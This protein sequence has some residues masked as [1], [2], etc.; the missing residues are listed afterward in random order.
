L[1]WLASSRFSI[2]RHVAV[3]TL[4]TAI[5]G[6]ALAS[7]IG[8]S[9]MQLE[10]RQQVLGSQAT[11]LRDLLR[12]QDSV[13]QWMLLSDLVLASNET[14]LI[15]GA[16]GQAGIATEIVAQIGASPLAAAERASLA[17]LTWLISDNSQ[18]LDKAGAL[19]PEDSS[20]LNALMRQWDDVATSTHMRA[21]A[22]LVSRRYQAERRRLV[23]ESLAALLLYGGFVAWLWRRVRRA[24]VEPLGRIT[25]A[26]DE[27]MRTGEPIDVHEEGPAEVRRL[28][29]SARS[30]ARVLE[31]RVQDR[32]AA[33][34][35][36][37]ETRRHAE[38]AADEARRTA[39]QA[40]AAKSQFIANMSHEIRTPLNGILGTAE[41]LLMSPLPEP[42]RER[43]ATVGS[44]G[45]LLLGIVNDI[46]DFSKIDAGRLTVQSAPLAMWQLVS[47]LQQ[48][49]SP[50]ALAAQLELRFVI[51]PETPAWLRA[52]ELRLKQILTNLLGNA[53]KFTPRGSVTLTIGCQGI[54]Q[55]RATLR[56]SVADT[57][58][59]ISTAQQAM[60]FE[61]FAQAD[62]S[63]T[64]R[65]GGTG[66][67]LS[68][69]DRLVQL[70]GGQLTCH[71]V[72]DRGSTFSFQLTLETVDAA[73]IA[74][75]APA[76]AAMPVDSRDCV[77]RVLL[78]EDNEVN[79]LVASE[80]LALLGCTV[81][82]VGDGRVATERAADN[83]YDLILMDWHMPNLDGL[84]ATRLIRARESG[85]G[86][87]RTP[88]IALTASA[89]PE[90][91]ARC[92][93]AGMDDFLP[94]PINLDGLRRVL[95]RWLPG[96]GTRLIV[97]AA[98]DVAN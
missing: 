20:A 82:V 55:R 26:A 22:G 43:L 54:D 12:L 75:R 29:R 40:N 66:L 19:T 81:E 78:A 56:F 13:R 7:T 45:R 2:G 65:Y 4:A 16:T 94:K 10:S 36:E 80:M 70:M 23:V 72:L 95:A 46:L 1:A 71:S 85:H 11:V 38:Q 53:V 88:I 5:G 96:A 79:Q 86:R 28:A 18:R 64:R 9:W 60:I 17:T 6:V 59:G 97:P 39:E 30:L 24:L 15:Q 51:D 35:R 41:L 61:P 49:L 98:R 14:Y 31:N 76:A 32:T 44:S 48:L 89:L 83:N 3:H 33:L 52:D 63:T 87:H 34:T 21:A 74:E 69:S 25:D 73:A 47:D 8:L 93:Q 68:I 67:G 90:D 27:A 77:A 57:G 91:A 42:T 50:Q 92:R 62:G 58:I 84:Q 37:I